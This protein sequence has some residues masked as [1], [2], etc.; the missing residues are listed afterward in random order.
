METRAS[1]MM[2]ERE[3]D[4]GGVGDLNKSYSRRK[5]QPRFAKHHTQQASQKES[6]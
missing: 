2:R 4:G 5:V 6:W 1:Q 3:E